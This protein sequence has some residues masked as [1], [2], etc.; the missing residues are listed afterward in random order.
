MVKS[1]LV[2]IIHETY[3]EL[4]LEKIEKIIN[5]FFEQLSYAVINKGVAELRHFGTFYTRL[6]TARIGRNPRTNNIIKIEEKIMPFFR[7]SQNLIKILN[8]E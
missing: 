4:K 7:P 6:K 1:E 5:I 8:I 3:P 2:K